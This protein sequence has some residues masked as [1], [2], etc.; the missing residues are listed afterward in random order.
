MNRR[1]SSAAAALVAG[2]ALLLTACGGGSDSKANDSNKVAGVDEPSKKTASPTSSRSPAI[3]GRPKIVLPADLTYSFDWPKTGDK[4]KDAVLFDSE[5]FIKARD[6]AIT[7][8]D[9]LH[10]AYRFYVEGD[11]A[12][13]TQAYV[14]DYVKHKARVTGFDRYYSDTVNLDKKGTATLSFCEDQGKSFDLY[15]KTGKIDKTPVSKNSYVLYNASLSKNDKGIW[16]TT[17]L[18]AQRGSVKCQP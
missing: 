11:M 3:A 6:M 7:E 12:A 15:L 8:Q 1:S 18:F 9:P 13:S 17:N 4:E 16:I 2:A 10:K 5:Q 14:E